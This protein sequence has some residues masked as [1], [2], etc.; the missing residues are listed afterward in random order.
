MEGVVEPM[1]NGVG[2]DLMAIVYDAKTKKI[3]GYNGSGRCGVPDQICNYFIFRFECC[4][5]V[6]EKS[7][8]RNLGS[9]LVNSNWDC[10]VWV[11]LSTMG[12]GLVWPAGLGVL[13]FLVG[14]EIRMC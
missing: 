2:G 4:V 7:I 13:M 5:C 14:S 11:K 3:H 1:M 9:V 12:A 6:R 10:Q 8:L